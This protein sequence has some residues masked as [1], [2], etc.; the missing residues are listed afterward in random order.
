MQI[1]LRTGNSLCLI[2]EMHLP[3]DFCQLAGLCCI[4][5]VFAFE[6]CKG[7]AGVGNNFKMKSRRA[8]QNLNC[9][10]SKVQLKGLSG[11]AGLE[12]R[13]RDTDTDTDTLGHL[14]A[15]GFVNLLA[16]CC[17]WPAKLMPNWMC[18]FPF[19]VMHLNVLF[20]FAQTGQL[21]SLK[22]HEKKGA[23][24]TQTHCRSKAN[25]NCN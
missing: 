25:K 23:K 9:S 22:L 12:T 24:N 4:S 6:S 8:S 17:S 11:L 13:T 2:S 18:Q 19:D 21:L 3:I 16:I 15:A 10:K 7:V 1:G 20:L 14:A 5:K